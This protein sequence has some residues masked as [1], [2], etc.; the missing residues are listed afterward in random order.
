MTD[1]FNSQPRMTTFSDGA[2]ASSSPSRCLILKF[3]HVVGL[4]REQCETSFHDEEYCPVRR[5]MLRR[6]LNPENEEESHER[7]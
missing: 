7:K 1:V 4:C 6:D 2:I 5:G 3:Q